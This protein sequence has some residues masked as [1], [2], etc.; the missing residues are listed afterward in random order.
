MKRNILMILIVV[1][2]GCYAACVEPDAQVVQSNNSNS[3]DPNDSIRKQIIEDL[4]RYPTNTGT[5]RSSAI[6]GAKITDEEMARLKE[7]TPQILAFA[8]FWKYQFG[9]P[10]DARNAAKEADIKEGNDWL[11]AYQ[12]LVNQRVDVYF[13]NDSYQIV[14]TVP[15]L[16]IAIVFNRIDGHN[17]DALYPHVLCGKINL[18][19]DGKYPCFWMGSYPPLWCEK[20]ELSS[21]FSI[22]LNQ[23]KFK[24]VDDPEKHA[25]FEALIKYAND[26][27]C[28]RLQTDVGQKVKISIP[29]FEVGDPGIY[30][31]ITQKPSEYELSGETIEWVDF[32][33]NAGKNQFLPKFSK[34]FGLPDELA[35]WAKIIRENTLKTLTLPCSVN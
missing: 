21:T 16:N 26:I 18:G 30:L 24:S 28:H 7:L 19:A 34:S 12:A 33:F 23:R 4:M 17:L 31:L 8:H 20:P 5:E 32:D 10:Y 35:H 13:V 15:I 29:N 25:L 22:T 6:L 9:C 11:N 14:V 3:S 1:F 27:A 2:G